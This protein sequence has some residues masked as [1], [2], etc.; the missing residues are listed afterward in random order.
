MVEA[1]R[2]TELYVREP[3]FYG[4]VMLIGCSD[5]TD[6]EVF[7]LKGVNPS[8]NEAMS[9]DMDDAMGSGTPDGVIDLSF[10]ML[11]DPLDQAGGG[12]YDFQRADCVVPPSMT[13]C[14]PADGATVSTFDYTS[15]AD[16]TCLEPDPAH[17]TNM[18]TPKPNTV[19]GACFA[20]SSA[21]LVLEL[22]DIQL[23]LTDAEV[24]AT[25]DADPADNFAPG[26]IKG[27]VSETDAQNT[28][29]PP[30]IQDATGATVL[31]DLL[32]GSPSNC[33]NHDDRDDNNG[34][35]GWWFYVDFVAER[36]PWTP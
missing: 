32:P 13:V 36:V 34:T 21:A 19:S 2:V 7:G 10:V 30:D 5:V 24:A 1:F 20:S 27:F 6:L 15:M 12:S 11:F 25:Y 33:A 17:L 3:H 9:T 14:S 29:L 23:P 35:S 18:Y 8:F 4:D 16:A 28:M 22:G 26:L 31:A